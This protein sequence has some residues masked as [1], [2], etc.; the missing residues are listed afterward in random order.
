MFP[1]ILIGAIGVVMI[2]AGAAHASEKPPQK[3]VTGSS[4]SLVRYTIINNRVT[5][6][7]T[8][9]WRQAQ[10]KA[11]FAFP[12]RVFL[13]ASMAASEYAS[14]SQQLKAAVMWAAKNYEKRY[15]TSLNSMLIPDGKLGGQKGRYASTAHPPT[16]TDVKLAQL[17]EGGSIKDPTGGA[18]QFDAPRTQ[19][20]LNKT[21]PKDHKTPEQV[22]SDRMKSG[23]RVVYLANEDPENARFWV[24]TSSTSATAAA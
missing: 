20:I 12:F 5:E 7:P 10:A 18:V 1:L 8:D 2:A 11:G 23:K 22:A 17:V 6:S 16:L 24:P 4:K 13:L 21:N 3:V 14:G 15:K 19:R 9:L